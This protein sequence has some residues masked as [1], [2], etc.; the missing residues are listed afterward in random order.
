MKKH[1]TDEMVQVIKNYLGKDG[2]AFFRELKEKYND[3][4]PVI[5]EGSLPHPVHFRE[6]MSVRNAL[7]NAKVCP[8]DWGPHEYDD[9]WTE[10]VERAIQ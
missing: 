7:R 3:I 1:I 6:G 8:K 10:I 9:N 2:I 4:S 5:I